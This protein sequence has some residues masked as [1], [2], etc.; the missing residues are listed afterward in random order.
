MISSKWDCLLEQHFGCWRGRSDLRVGGSH[1]FE[2]TAVLVYRGS[3]GQH[4][5]SDKACASRPALQPIRQKSCPCSVYRR[6]RRKVPCGPSLYL[7]AEGLSIAFALAPCCR[8]R[9]KLGAWRPPRHRTLLSGT[10]RLLARNAGSTGRRKEGA[11]GHRKK[12]ENPSAQRRDAFASHAR[13]TR[14]RLQRPSPALHQNDVES[15]AR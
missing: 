6:F 12:I 5:R 13:S 4:A 14:G 9:G 10:A 7:V 1:C 3:H 11:T 8:R 15:S 2:L